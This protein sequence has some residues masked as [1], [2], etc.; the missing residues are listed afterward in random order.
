MTIECRCASFCTHAKQFENSFFPPMKSRSYRSSHL[1]VI[2]N[3]CAQWSSVLSCQLFIDTMQISARDRNDSGNAA[4]FDGK[5]FFPIFQLLKSSRSRPRFHVRDS[6]K[7]KKKEKRERK[8]RF[9]GAVLKLPGVFFTDTLCVHLSSR[10]PTT[11]CT[12]FLITAPERDGNCFSI[13][14]AAPTRVNSNFK[15][16]PLDIFACN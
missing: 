15:L 1:R 12:L 5:M 10:S 16:T 3:K 8:G 9:F 13:I 4:I 11:I 14:A 2:I 6:V 7:K